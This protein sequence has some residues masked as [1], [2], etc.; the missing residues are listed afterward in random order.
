M[1]AAGEGTAGQ[2]MSR[3]C[4]ISMAPATISLNSGDLFG[5]WAVLPSG[6]MPHGPRY[7]Q[8]GARPRPR[9]ATAG[10]LAERLDVFP[11]F[12]TESEAAVLKFARSATCRTEIRYCD[13]AF[14]R[15]G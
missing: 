4:G 15:A 6:A 1:R 12:G 2:N 5:G 8:E 14:H 13:H 9:I 11:N 10:V 7:P 3:T